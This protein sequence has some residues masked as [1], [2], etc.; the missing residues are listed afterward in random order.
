[1][2]KI[3]FQQLNAFVLKY[4]WEDVL[5]IYFAKYLAY[6]L[7][8]SIFLFLLVS[9]KKYWS[10][11]VKALMAG[12][13]A[14]FGIVELIRYFFPRPRPFLEEN[15]NLLVDKINQP[16]FP[17]GHAAFFFALSFIVFLYNKKAGLLFFIASILIC[18]G[19]VI[20]GVH[21]PSDILVGA[22]VGLFS[23]WLVY[24]IFN[25]LK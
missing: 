21:W 24:K 14:R 4:F 17:S 10:M 18:L 19:R 12:I 16:A 2:D 15:V 11:I 3:I 23:G 5:F 9:F 6:L 8:L 20:V 25:F 13:L 22:M 1:M 7:G